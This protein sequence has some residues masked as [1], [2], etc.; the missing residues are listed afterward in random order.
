MV[1]VRAGK[2]YPQRR[3]RSQ[4]YEHS[5]D[6]GRHPNLLQGLGPWRQ[7]IVFHHG[8]PLSSDD[9]DTQMLFF[10][11]ARLPRHRARPPRPRPL[12]P[13]LDGHD[14]DHYAADAAAVVE[15]FDL[16]E[17]GPYRPLDR[18]RRSGSLCRASRQGPGRQGGADVA[19]PPIMVKSPNNPAACRS[20]CSTAFASSSLTIA[21]Q[22]YRDVAYRPVLRLQSA[23]REAV[24]RASS[25]IG[26]G[27]A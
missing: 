18:R 19:V 3:R 12:E 2:I 13:G 6:E 21:P 17:R 8:W 26:G 9:W 27:R 22:F 5:H 7:P 11:A 4:D 25:R 24:S 23:G 20:R 16:R 1:L 15:H 10:V 14:M